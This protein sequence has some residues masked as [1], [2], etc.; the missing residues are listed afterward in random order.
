MQRIG[1]FVSGMHVRWT[2]RH[3]R[4]RCGVGQEVQVVVMQP[5]QQSAVVRIDHFAAVGIEESGCF[6]RGDV[7]T[8]HQYVNA[9]AGRHGRVADQKTGFAQSHTVVLAGVGRSRPL[10]A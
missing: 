2:A 4:T 6:H 7:V 10:W 5:G 1:Q 3:G 8:A 9:L